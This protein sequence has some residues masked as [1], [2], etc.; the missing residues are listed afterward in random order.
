MISNNPTAP[1]AKF[2]CDTF[3]LDLFK[4]V[5]TAR[6]ILEPFAD[7]ELTTYGGVSNER[8]NHPTVW[9]SEFGMIAF[10]GLAPGHPHKPEHYYHGP[11]PMKWVS[12]TFAEAIRDA[13]VH[14]VTV[15]LMQRG[16]WNAGVLQREFQTLLYHLRKWNEQPQTAARAVRA[17]EN[18]LVAAV[19]DLQFVLEKYPNVTRRAPTNARECTND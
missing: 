10:F 12:C 4:A 8:L 19:A 9:N 1:E 13:W 7:V 6:Q 17:V 16:V 5:P 15:L 11:D 18:S 14:G 3:D 2:W